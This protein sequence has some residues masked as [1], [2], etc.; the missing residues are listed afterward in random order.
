MKNYKNG[1]KIPSG[2]SKNSVSG[3][4]FSFLCVR[5]VQMTKKTTKPQAYRIGVI[6]LLLLYGSVCWM[7]GLCTGMLINNNVGFYIGL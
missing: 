7:L 2:G 5:E 3:N 4:V 1:T 6:V